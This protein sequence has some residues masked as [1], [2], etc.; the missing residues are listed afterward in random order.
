LTATP[1]EGVYIVEHS[2]VSDVRG[3]MTRLLDQDMKEVL[4][5][6]SANQVLLS[7]TRDAGTVRGIHMQVHP[8]GE[9]KLVS[10]LGGEILDVA[11]DLR[12]HSSTFGSW[13]SVHLTAENNRSLLVPP[14][15]GHGFQS[16]TNGCEV[17]YI[18][19]GKYEPQAERVLNPM[20]CDVA[21][22]WPLTVR[23]LSRRDA[24]GAALCAFGAAP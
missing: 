9:T 23:N 20:D 11:V 10:C 19:H 7:R 15:C 3:S 4:A 21:I 14:G 22:K 17:L 8:H 1:I 2:Q 16:Q 6:D 13:T 12:P 5:V 18:I 24:S